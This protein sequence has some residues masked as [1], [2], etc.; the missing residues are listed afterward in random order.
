MSARIEITLT[1]AVVADQAAKMPS[2]PSETITGTTSSTIRPTEKISVR[3]SIPSVR[4]CEMYAKSRSIDTLHSATL[5]IS[6]SA[7]TGSDS[8]SKPP[9]LS[10]RTTTL[11]TPATSPMAT[12]NPK[13]AFRVADQSQSSRA[14][15]SI[16]M[17][18]APS[19]ALETVAISVIAATRAAPKPTSRVVYAR[20]ATTQN[21][22][23]AAEETT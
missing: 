6:A 23:P 11:T 12:A 7:Y 14:R 5:A 19:P 16:W 3:W 4:R 10:G 21:T 22:N 13:A 18:E 17:S 15:G 20:A 9:E 8:F 2:A 1:M